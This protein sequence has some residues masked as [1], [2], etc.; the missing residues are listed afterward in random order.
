M[1]AQT[2]PVGAITRGTTN[3]NRLRR[4]DRYL[5]G[6]LAPLL[7][8]AE[9]PLLVDLGFGAA[10]ITTV[11]LWERARTVRPDVEL[12]G[13]EI[14]PDRVAAARGHA[15]PG[16]S[17][18]RGGF[19]IP[20]E[21][22]SPVFVRAF[23]V[24]RQYPV[25]EVPAAWELACSRLAPGGVLMDGT[26]DEIGRLATWLCC[27]VRRPQTF[28]VSMRPGSFRVPSD[29]AARL[30]KI[31]IHRNVPGERIHD[32]LTAADAAWLANAPLSPFGARQRWSA[33]CRDL[34][35]AGW[36]VLHGPRRWRLG[37]VSVPWEAVAPSSWD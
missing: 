14:D 2:R 32:F 11:E 7:R 16:L 5:T 27:T 31:L 21:P 9:D 35:A 33:M 36:P 8:A 4:A 29:V 34:K 26:C 25:Q 37:E 17:F 3:P 18:R 22:R 6:V 28:T 23:N 1:P 13:I 24:L 15:R 12:V 20:T 19:E 10:P 30:P